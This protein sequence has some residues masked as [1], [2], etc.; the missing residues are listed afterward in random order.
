VLGVND[1]IIDVL[2]PTRDI[3]HLQLSKHFIRV[4]LNIFQ[5]RWMS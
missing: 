3:A 1:V 5:E 2:K 4:F